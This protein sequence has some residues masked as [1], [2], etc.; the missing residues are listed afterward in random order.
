MTLPLLIGGILFV[1]TQHLHA[2]VYTLPVNGDNVIGSTQQATVQKGDNFYK[3]ARRNDVGYEELVVANPSINPNKIYPGQILHIPSRY[4][5]PEVKSI[6]G[7]VI[8]L[9]ER[10][11]YYFINKNKV[12]TAPIAIGRR[13]WETPVANAFIK[14]K[15]EDPFWKVPKRIQ[16]HNKKLGKPS[17]SLI[18]PGS[19]NPLG[20][21]AMV[22]SLPNYVIHGTNDPTTIGKRISAGCIRLYPEDM[23]YLYNNIS[24]ETPVSIINQPFKMGRLA[25]NHFI[26]IHQSKKAKKI[27]DDFF[28]KNPNLA[29]NQKALSH[30]IQQGRGIPQKI[31]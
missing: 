7:L 19:D 24:L 18:P 25:G 30:I 29:I 16:A 10:R 28:Q 17:P 6:P 23:R 20:E 31:N 15:V 21:Y 3:I 1:V 12:F 9:A 11:L 13:G 14:R 27:L 8:N 26:E 5:L 22:L 4:I 2:M